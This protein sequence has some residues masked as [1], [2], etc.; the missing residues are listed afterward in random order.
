M[1]YSVV[2]VVVVVVVVGPFSHA[3]FFSFFPP[4]CCLLG[5][6]CSTVRLTVTVQL[7]PGFDLCLQSDASGVLQLGPE[8]ARS[9]GNR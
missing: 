8:T 3:V 1:L 4:T 9:A 5:I 2:V 6:I 7:F